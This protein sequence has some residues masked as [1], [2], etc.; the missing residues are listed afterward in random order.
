MDDDAASHPLVHGA[1]SL[2]DLLHSP[3]VLTPDPRRVVVLPFQVSISSRESVAGVLA[4]IK[5]VVGAVSAMAPT[6]RGAALARL[7]S[8]FAGRHRA[9]R[10]LCLERFGQIRDALGGEVAL[11]DDQATLAGAYF[12]HEYSFQAAAV[13]NPSVVRHPDQANLPAGAVRF[14]LSTRCLGEGHISTIAFRE[15]VF[16]ADGAVDLTPCDTLAVAA[17]PTHPGQSDGPVSLVRDSRAGLSETVIFPATRAQANGLE[18]LRLVE[19]SDGGERTYLGT[20]TAFSGRDVCC[21]LFETRDFEHFRLV[22]MRGAATFHK[23]LALFPRKINDRYAAI[24]RLDH[25]S[26]YYLESDDRGVW[27]NGDRI[28]EPR[29]DWDLMQVGNC[30]APVELDEGWLLITHGVGPLRAYALG[31]ALLDKQ[32]P[33]RVLARGR[34]PLLAPS[35]DGRDGYA[36][37]VVY[38]CGFLR[39]GEWILLPYATADTCIRFASVRVRDLLAYLEA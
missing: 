20:Y 3:L 5:R 4:R 15:G 13:L 14:I 23:A 39:H 36:P 25:E 10:D 9:F 22:P 12:S 16:H 17:R 29:H 37:N 34:V 38:S 18:D 21:E 8:E 27:N 19:F 31:A 7:D 26:L 28:L 6:E 30:G 24:G 32:D 11:D 35:P 2:V 33:R 1:F